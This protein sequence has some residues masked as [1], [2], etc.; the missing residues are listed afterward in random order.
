M[1]SSHPH[2][3]CLATLLALGGAFAIPAQAQILGY[4]VDFNSGSTTYSDNFRTAGDA[5]AAGFTWSASAGT[6]GTGGLT[7]GNT[8]AN[9]IFYRPNVPNNATSTFDL[10]SMAAGTSILATTDFVWSNITATDSTVLTAGFVPNNAT[11]NALTSSGALAGSVIRNAGTSTVTLRMRNGTGNAATLDFSQS[12]LTAGSWYQLSYEITK[13][14]TANTFDYTVS[15]YSLGASGT[16]TPVLFNDGT[17]NITLSGTLTN[18]MIYS[19]ANAFF[20]YDIRDTV[21]DTGITRVDNFDV[22]VV[23][24]PTAAPLVMAALAGLAGLRRRRH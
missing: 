8:G 16:G 4:D 7:V 1:K 3:R 21:G 2:L 6:G 12:A 24:E 14:S 9:N 11:S 13:S 15:L 20:A 18:S 22:H 10:A 23:P 17:N 19:D 5:A